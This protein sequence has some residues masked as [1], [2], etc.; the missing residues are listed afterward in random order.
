MSTVGKQPYGI[1]PHILQEERQRG[2]FHY[3][4]GLTVCFGSRIRYSRQRLLRDRTDRDG[5]VVQPV[6]SRDVFERLQVSVLGQLPSHGEGVPDSSPQVVWED[7][8][9]PFP[10]VANSAR[11]AIFVVDN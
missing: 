3:Q 2:I 7:C 8:P 1:D 11:Q 6:G 9:R 10:T 5:G 4:C